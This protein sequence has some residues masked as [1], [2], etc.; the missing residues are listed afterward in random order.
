VIISK[1]FLLKIDSLFENKNNIVSQNVIC[2]KENSTQI[3]CNATFFYLEQCRPDQFACVFV[4]LSYKEKLGQKIEHLKDINETILSKLFPQTL[5]KIDSGIIHSCSILCFRLISIDSTSKSDSFQRK[6][7]VFSEVDKII[8]Q[9]QKICFLS[10][11]QNILFFL[12]YQVG[13]E[14]EHA[15]MVVEAAFLIKTTL[16]QNSVFSSAKFI[17]ALHSGG[18]FYLDFDDESRNQVYFSSDMI[19]LTE[20]MCY[21]DTNKRIALSPDIYE[22]MASRGY[23]FEMCEDQ[24]FGKYFSILPKETITHN[25]VSNE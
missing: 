16:E 24:Y 14:I 18:P 6:L 5:L 10:S 7:D 23:L 20:R 22:I 17:I 9:N 3:E 21:L 8:N 2:V 13:D 4:D 19:E 1:N 12:A 15:I 11:H 25:P